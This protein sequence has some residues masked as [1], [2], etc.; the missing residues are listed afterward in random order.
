MKFSR[1]GENL[2]KI[3][4]IIFLLSFSLL[5]ISIYKTRLEGY[6]FYEH[7]FYLPIIL[8]SFWWG[9]K[10]ISTAFFLDIF[11]ILIAFYSNNPK[12]IFSAFI[13]STLILITSSLVGILSEEKMKAL[14]EEREF[15][16]KA[17]HYFFNPIAIAE[18]FIEIAKEKS[19]G[20]REE[21]ELA[22]NSIERIK[23]VVKNVV[24]KGEIKE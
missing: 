21:L 1:A 20:A 3:L 17:A 2:V 5:L 14:E 15:R 7:F 19:S 6:T 24:E 18:G 23:K 10:G 22:F 4:S 16:M 8:S 13:K 11:I 12:E 9:K